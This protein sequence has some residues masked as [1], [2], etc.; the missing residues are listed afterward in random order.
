MGK[1]LYVGNLPYDTDEAMLKEA[2]G[3]EGR[4]V[5]TVHVVMDRETGRPRGFAFVEMASEGDAQKAIAAMDGAV[6]CGRNLRVNEAEDR[7]GP[8]GGPR[9]GGGGFGGPRPG[10][11]GGPGGP[12]PPSGPRNDGPPRTGGFSGGGSGGGGAGGGFSRP[13]PGWSDAPAEP[14]KYEKPKPQR[15]RGDE[16]E[17]YGGRR[18]GRRFDDDDE[19]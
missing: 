11:P 5:A 9:P 6:F 2:F 18:G 15:R 3:Q 4:T 8:A 17:D 19:Y 12:R 13:K 14:K 16:D 7:R 1:R 10:G